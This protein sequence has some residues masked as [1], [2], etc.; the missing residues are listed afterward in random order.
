MLDQG[1]YLVTVK[2]LM[3]EKRV[4]STARYTQP[5]KH[6]LR[7]AVRRLELEEV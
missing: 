5:S 2:E 3:G 7:V 4:E 1:V 6:D